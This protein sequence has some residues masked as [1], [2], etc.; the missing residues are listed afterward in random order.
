MSIETEFLAFMQT[1]SAITDLVGT[2]VY[3][4]VFESSMTDYPSITYA[5][6]GHRSLMDADGVNGLANLRLRLRIYSLLYS[7][8]LD[9]FAEID[10]AF[11]GYQGV[12]ITSWAHSIFVQDPVDLKGVRVAA[13]SPDIRRS[14]NVIIN[15]WYQ[16]GI[17]AL[18]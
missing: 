4:G 18:V 3:P 12:L 9:V 7:E 16:R 15:M 14:R 8:I 13:G 5:V 2:R 10:D 11:N 17:P 6:L 1:K